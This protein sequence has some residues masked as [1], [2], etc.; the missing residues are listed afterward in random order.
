MP[1]KVTIEAL[2]RVARIS[3]AQLSPD[4]RFIVFVVAQANLEKNQL[5]SNLWLLERESG[6]T[7]QLSFAVAGR[8]I[9]PR[10]SPNG[11]E[12]AFLSD[13]AEGMQLWILS[14][15][16]GEARQITHIVT[17]VDSFLWSP[18]GE[19]FALVSRV[20]TDCPDWPAMEQR[21]KEWE[22]RLVKA[23]TIT[24]VPFRRWDSWVDERRAHIFIMRADGTN[25]RDLTPGNQ[26][27]PA[28]SEG[29]PDAY[30]FS[31]DGRTICFVGVIGNEALDDIRALFF[32][33]L[34]V[35]EP[36]QITNNGAHDFFPR[37]SQDGTLAYLATKRPHLDGDHAHIMLRNNVTGESVRLTGELDRSV[38]SFVWAADG[39]SIWFIVEDHGEEMIYQLSLPT[40]KLK[41]YGRTSNL[42]DLTITPDG[43]HLIF[44][45]SSFSQ[46]AEIYQAT[47]STEFS[48]QQLSH[49]NDEWRTS[50]LWSEVSSFTYQGW[51]DEEVMSWL[52]KP[53]DFSPDRRYPL[54][55]LIHGGP[56]RAWGN[57]FHY[58]WNPQVFAAAGYIVLIP[59]FHGSSSYGQAFT[60]QIRGDWGNIVFED[61]MCAVDEAIKWPFIDSA[62]LAAAGGSYGGYMTN[63]LAGHTNRF[64]CLIS[65]SGLY[66]LISSFYAADFVGDTKQELG[67]TPWENLEVM[68]LSS[69][70]TFAGNFVTPMLISHGQLD[71]RVDVSDSFAMFQVLRAKGV[72]TKLLYFPDE[73]HWILKPGNSVYWYKEVL[74][75]LAH[76]TTP[77]N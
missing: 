72:P 30:T 36:R 48:L 70:S 46:P 66:N 63:W 42:N 22:K 44:L 13:R 43:R 68:H 9:R 40:G 25:L 18:N 51:H 58:R 8:N 56:H 28:W 75:W 34:A 55:L 31:P 16:G 12:I 14:L 21:H 52:V 45:R 71:Y 37:F 32:V 4:G 53:P 6:R 29:G 19:H 41:P 60:D 7:R 64:R 73:N 65:H 38:N 76:W 11:R 15:E 39:R 33:D 57:D 3:D 24:D 69:P 1:D 54:L 67:G 47:T 61:L 5:V 17:E 50:L 27:A 23:R 59:N 26:D 77:T 35:G 2:Q 49:L 62:R 10:W 74:A 20:Y